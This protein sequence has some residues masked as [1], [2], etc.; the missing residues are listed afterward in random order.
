MLF[1]FGPDETVADFERHLTDDSVWIGR[2]GIDRYRHRGR[3]NV[4]FCDW[5]VES[6]PTTEGGLDT[7]GLS[8]GLHR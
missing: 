6:V 3:A 4:L 8:K 1:D 7:I 2:Q 5:H